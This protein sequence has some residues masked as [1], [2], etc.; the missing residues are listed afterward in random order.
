VTNIEKNIA[1]GKICQG[2]LYRAR[3]RAGQPAV[4]PQDHQPLDGHIAAEACPLG[5]F[6]KGSGYEIE[7][8]A[9]V[10]STPKAFLPTTLSSV[11]AAAI[12]AVADK[13]TQAVVPSTPVAPSHWPLFAKKAL[14]MA[15][16]GEKGVGDTIARIVG[17]IGGNAFKAWYHKVTGGSC[18]CGKRQIELNKAYPY[19]M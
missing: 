16:P 17:P 4:C 8:T 10:E 12:N 19:S 6:A 3:I 13:V 14:E 18:T 15:Q 2:C 9:D 7:T 11:I 5:F 1:L